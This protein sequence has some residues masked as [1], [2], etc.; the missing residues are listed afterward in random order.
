VLD[1][2]TSM[3]VLAI[4]APVM[5]GIALLIKLD[6]PGP[7]V[8]KHR[9]IGLNRRRHISSWPLHRE[10]REQDLYG[11]PF[12]LYKFR[13][14]LADAKDRFPELYAYDY[15]PEELHSLPIKALVGHKEAARASDGSP[16]VPDPRLTTVGRWLRRT[17]LDEFPNF[18]NVLR[19]DM[20]LVGPRADIVENIRYYPEHHRAKLD[21]KP[22]V[23]GLAQVNGR[24]ALSFLRTN[25]LDLEYVRNRSLRLDLKI[26]WRTLL[27]TLRADGAY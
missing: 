3:V 27:V 2:V 17:S 1:L 23:T 24:G 21:V 6:S 7:V 13:T 25:E 22:G 5:A 12:T 9:R 10:R 18:I 11:K 15:T 19:G 14:M 8:F 26:I 20:H 16:E 4:G